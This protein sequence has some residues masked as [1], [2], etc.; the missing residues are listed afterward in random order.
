MASAV[1]RRTEVRRVILCLAFAG[2]LTAAVTPA[3]AQLTITNPAVENFPGVTLDGSAQTVS[4]SLAGFSVDDARGTGEGWRVMVQATQFAEHDGTGY[5]T[6]GKTLPTSSLRMPAPMV[7]ANGTSS[8]P[9]TIEPGA[10]WAID[11][12]AAV[13]IASAAV[14][15]GMGRYDFGSVSLSLTVPASAYAKTYRSDVTVSVVSGP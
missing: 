10:P 14:D 5:V 13:K 3:G 4:A 7:T 11:V 6:G 1:A 12:A 2:G 15:T 9:P 8:P